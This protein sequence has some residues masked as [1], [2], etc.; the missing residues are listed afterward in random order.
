MSVNTHRSFIAFKALLAKAG[1]DP[2]SV[3][4]EVLLFKLSSMPFEA[5]IDVIARYL[6]G[7]IASSL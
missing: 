4:E 5:F 1:C 6:L 2:V 7:I 3:T